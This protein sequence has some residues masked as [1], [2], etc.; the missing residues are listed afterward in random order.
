MMRRP[1]HLHEH[2]TIDPS[3]TFL[4]HGSFGACPHEVLD[5]QLAWRTRMESQPLTFFVRDLWDCLREARAQ[6]A[7]FVGAKPSDLAFV[8]NATQGVNTVLRSLSWQQGDLI[9]T[10]DHAYNACRQALAWL[11]QRY[12]VDVHVVAL[13]FPVREPALLEASVLDAVAALPK[14]PKLALLDHITSA[15]ALILPIER[16]VA[17]LEEQGIPVLVDG[18]HGPG[19]VPLALDVLGASYYTGNCHKWLC[20]PKA[21]AFLHVRAD[22]QAE[23]VPLSISHGFDMELPNTSAFAQNFAWTGTQDVSAHLCV[24]QALETLSSMVEGGWDAIQKMN[25]ALVQQG[26]DIVCD[27]LEVEPCAPDSMTGSIATIP[28]SPLPI[29]TRDVR[30]VMDTLPLQDWLWTEEKIEVPVML[31]PLQDESGH[32][33]S[34]LVLRISAHLYNRLEDYRHL[35]DALLRYMQR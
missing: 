2:W 20:A 14:R 19:M 35:A 5:A 7:A 23:I 12:G 29:E 3:V 33:T 4:N 16:W 25:K 31:W 18:A 9:L 24:P 6:L 27:A 22:R 32:A 34:S 11:E 28:L 1:E 17:A 10:T 30:E 21:A 13:P 26:R 15:T 8:T